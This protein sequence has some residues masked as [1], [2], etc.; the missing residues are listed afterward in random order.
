M[1]T[2]NV[3]RRRAGDDA[4]VARAAPVDG[5]VSVWRTEPVRPGGPVYAQVPV[6]ELDDWLVRGWQVVGGDPGDGA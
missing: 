4:P 6:A 3:N 2:Q 1:A 5:Q